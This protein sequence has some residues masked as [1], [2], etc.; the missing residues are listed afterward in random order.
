MRKFLS[1]LSM[2]VLL[3]TLSIAQTKN[4]T[5]KVTDDQGQAVPFATV[6]VK[7]SKQGVA[8]NADG[9]FAIK[10]KPAE[11][12]VI[13]GAGV[14]T[15]EITVGNESSLNIQIVRQTGNLSEVVVTTALGIQRKRN[16]L[17][18]SAQQI[19]GDDLNKA[20][21]S[22]NP[23][24]NL[25]GKIAGLQITQESTMGGSTNVILRG[26]KSLTQSNQ[27]L[28]VIDGVPFDNTNQSQY[29]YDMGNSASDINPDDI[30]SVSVLKGAAASALYGSRASNGVVMINT[31]K[32]NKKK[33]VG[34]IVSFGATAGSLDKSTLPTYQTEYGEGYMGNLGFSS[35]PTFF[36]TTPVPISETPNDAATGPKYDPTQMVYQWDA[37][38]PGDP[39]YGKATPW[40]AAA[41]HNP[42]D[43][44]VT[45]VTTA[46]SLY[47]SGSGDK[48]MF[49]LS[50]S[51]DADN[52]FV[53][54]SN[55]KKNLISFSTNYKVID[56]VSV[57][58]ALD[59]SDVSAL[60]RYQYPYGSGYA[61]LG[62][63]GA[64][65]DFRQ[66]WPTNVDLHQLKRDYFATG[67]NATWNWQIPAYT[68]NSSLSQ[69]GNYA[70]GTTPAYHDN[71]YFFLN[72]N[73]E[74]DSRTRFF[75]N[76]HIDWTINSFLTAM[77]RVSQDY[78]TQL[79]EMRQDIGSTGTPYYYRSNGQFGETNYDF[80]LNLN[81]NIGTNFNIK[82]LLG[83][84]VRQTT[85]Q[86]I[87]AG[88][89]G[90]LVVPGFFA[91]SNSVKT[92]TAPSEY[93][94]QK[95]VDGIFAGATLTY[96]DLI[97]LDGTVRRDQSSTL[98]SKNNSY[99]YPEG[100]INFQF[101]KLLRNVNWLS[102]GKVWGNYAEVG[103]DAPIFSI[104]NTYVAQT[105]ISGQTMFS[106]PSTNN[107]P[108]LLPERQKG[109]ET[110]IEASFLNDRVGFNV[111][112][113]SG[114]QI[115]QI[116]PANVSTS[117]GFSTFYVNG[118]AIQNSG[119]E[120]SLNLTPV[121]T[122]NFSWDINA[123]W[124][125]QKQKVLSLYNGQPLYAVAN[126]QNSVRLVA[127]PGKPY[128]L[129]GTAYTYLNGQ[130]EVDATTGFPILK[131]GQY[132]D[133]GTPNPDWFGG[134][135]NTFR[136]KNL[137]L[138][139]LVDMRHG[140]KVYSLDMDYGSFSGLYPRTAG[141]NSTG[142]EVRGDLSSGGG[143]VFKG[144]TPD[145]K[146]NTTKIDESSL[147]NGAWTFG[148][149][150]GAEAHQEFVYDAS[151]VK[152]REVA[153]TYSIPAKSFEKGGSFIKG[154]DV[155]ITGRNLWIIHKNEPYADPEQGQAS[156]NASIGYQNGAYPSVRTIG[157]L[158]KFKF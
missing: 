39:N 81:K 15:K 123:N 57:G 149:L 66:W 34:V 126:Y 135:N 117:T 156:G 146:P 132:N 36:S 113:F 112:Y 93:Y 89:N 47:V 60:N 35:Y 32:G 145:G 119:V 100:S 72:K 31:K 142:G 28:F 5:G 17:A 124:S 144:V 86:S 11:I 68:A 116:M 52:D 61:G 99:Y 138:S 107:N 98:P 140:G 49:K 20:A 85:T 14:V 25:S 110:G 56:K 54:N 65:T 105:P 62:Q 71:P 148:S 96:K 12:L 102:H 108:N 24:S 29:G 103:G 155:S 92:P 82:A 120:V 101:G 88:T 53:P 94:G 51:H 154:I 41:H 22:I 78:Y 19:G 48:G 69:V 151:Y 4:V 111:A 45:P 115:N 84:N 121:R 79:I 97:T 106:T 50:Y 129:Q 77:A 30:E 55:L 125:A 131:A 141:K 128:Q 23:V 1:L 83:T 16:T 37:F 59:Y 7:G 139:F 46:T 63:L 9:V 2:L 6:R 58:V 118:G 33:G 147:D 157:G 8:A 73:F 136:Y 134:I 75:G 114:K 26:I 27:A 150:S 74:T 153:L 40:Q 3:S 42:T 152:L 70:A 137:A 38:M 43:F 109:W 67:T 21:V 122:R 143:Y 133:L 13:T 158:V 44:F 90:G 87:S 76:I 10:V 127:E 104:A 95:E 18:Y 130:R 64:M 91:L 80:L